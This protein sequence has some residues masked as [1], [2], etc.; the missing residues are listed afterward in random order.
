MKLYDATVNFIAQAGSVITC[1]LHMPSG[2]ARRSHCPL[3]ARL[4]NSRIGQGDDLSWL[5]FEKRPVLGR[6]HCSGSS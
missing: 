3:K 5:K 4:Y 6:R 1:A 2:T